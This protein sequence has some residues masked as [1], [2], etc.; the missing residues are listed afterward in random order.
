MSRG[1]II[2]LIGIA[3]LL[4]LMALRMPIGI[5]ML[6]VGIVGFGVLN[7]VQCRARGARNLSLS[8]CG[9]LRLR[10]HSAVRADGQ[11]RLGVRNGARSLCRRLFL[12]RPCARRARPRHH[13]RLRGLCRGLRIER[14]LGGDH[15]QGLPARDAALRL[16]PS[17]LHR[18]DRGRRHARHPDSAEHGFRHLR[19]AHR[20]VDR[21]AAARRH[22]A[23][24]AAHG[25]FHGHG[26]DLDALPPAI[27]SARA[28]RDL[29][30]AQ[31]E[32]GAAPAR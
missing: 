11:S 5:A 24:A 3:V 9:G 7:G 2:G 1:D 29:E 14:R 19:A 21:P 17:P 20:A 25:H 16:Q 31:T 28:A 18:R 30:G 27:W 26:R 10:R 13:P 12:D 6:L 8:I 15:G 32:P 22:P 4:L 23:G